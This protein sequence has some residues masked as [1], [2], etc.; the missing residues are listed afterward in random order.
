MEMEYAEIADD[1]LELL[2][3][4]FLTFLATTPIPLKCTDELRPRVEPPPGQAVRI[5][6]ASTLSKYAG[7]IFRNIWSLFPDHPDFEGLDIN[8]QTDIPEWWKIRRAR[9]E[10]QVKDFH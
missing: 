10:K 9:F 5:V 7:K 8:K 4:H 2:A 1:L 3:I 6:V